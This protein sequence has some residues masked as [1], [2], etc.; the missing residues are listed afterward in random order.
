KIGRAVCSPPGPQF[1]VQ[2]A[3]AK[4]R[5][6]TARCLWILRDIGVESLPSRATGA[7]LPRRYE[8]KS[9]TGAYGKKVTGG[10]R[11][12]VHQRNGE[13][14]WLESGSAGVFTDNTCNAST[15]A[16]QLRGA[17]RIGRH[18]ARGRPSREVPPSFSGR[19]L[20]PYCC[21]RKPENSTTANRAKGAASRGS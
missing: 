6:S 15:G 14:Q 20:R 4:F 8:Q 1:P 5:T 19:T 3:L 16:L 7:S 11:E 18:S 21:R 9:G 17:Q 2:E 10:V 12:F 13:Q